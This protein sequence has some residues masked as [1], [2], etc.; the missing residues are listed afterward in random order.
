MKI[1][2]CGK[3]GVGKT[4]IAG[5]LVR[6]LADRGLSVL[7]VDADPTP[8]LAAVLGIPPE[9]AAALQPLPRT[10]LEPR[11]A[12]DGGTVTALARPWQDVVQQYGVPVD[13]RITLLLMGRVDHA[14]SG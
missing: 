4:T 9:R 6:A 11:Q 12:A 1:A 3:G 7:A 10:L 14:G 13:E 5:A 8:N 2:I